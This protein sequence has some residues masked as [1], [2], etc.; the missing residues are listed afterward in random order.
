VKGGNALLFGVDVIAEIHAPGSLSALVEHELFHRYHAQVAPGE[1]GW[2]G[3]ALYKALWEEGLAT[4]VSHTLN[5]QVSEAEILGRPVDLAQ[6]ARPLLSQLAAEMLRHFDSRDEEIYSRF[7]A[8]GEHG[9]FPPRS[10][11]FVGHHVAQEL[12]GKYSLNELARLQGDSL[13][14]AV[15]AVLENMAQN[16][17][18]HRP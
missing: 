1:A 13:R 17:V 4:Y 15:H 18:S 12:A 10:G 2:M 14:D 11:Y 9:R 16:S 3:S 8:G 6:R 5:P 7:F